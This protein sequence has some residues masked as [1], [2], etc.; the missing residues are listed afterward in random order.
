MYTVAAIK[1]SY[2]S[3]EIVR[4]FKFVSVCSF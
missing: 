4:M 3:S 1:L 2:L